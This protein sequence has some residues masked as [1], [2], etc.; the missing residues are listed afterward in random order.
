MTPARCYEKYR[1]TALSTLNLYVS[2]VYLVLVGI[3]GPIID[4]WNVKIV[5]FLVGL[6]S[7]VTILPRGL[8]LA[9]NH[10]KDKF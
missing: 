5:Y 1:T 8:Y 7:L 3:S 2:L 10:I 9:K 4:H 6:I